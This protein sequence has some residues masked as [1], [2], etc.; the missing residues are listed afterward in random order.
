MRVLLDTHILLWALADDPKLSRKAVRLIED[1]SEVYISAA[2]FWELAIKIS[3]GKLD[4][5]LDEI[6]ECCRE[7]GFIELPTAIEH[8]LAIREIEH[9][10]RDP[11]DHMLVAVAI[12]EPMRL[13]TAEAMVARYSSLAVL[14]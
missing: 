13:L 7:S 11:F 3:I 6:R 4:A 8:A 1:A 5:D 14:V 10:H 12:T 9:H 2:T